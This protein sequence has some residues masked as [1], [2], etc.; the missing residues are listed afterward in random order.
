MT[1]AELHIEAA[2]LAKLK[3]KH[4][5]ACNPGAREEAARQLERVKAE[6]AKRTEDY[7]TD[8]VDAGLV[9]LKGSKLK[10]PANPRLVYA[11][12]AA[13]GFAGGETGFINTSAQRAFHEG[14]NLWQSILAIVASL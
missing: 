3:R 2:R 7:S 1:L 4:H 9:R 11:L 10:R 13:L 5:L 14:G 6:I 12:W 8:E